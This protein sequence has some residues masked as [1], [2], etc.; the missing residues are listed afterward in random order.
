VPAATALA[1]VPADPPAGEG[2]AP[3]AT[4]AAEGLAQ[5]IRAV[6][7]A[8]GTTETGPAL[9]TGLRTAGMAALLRVRHWLA[10]APAVR[11]VP[12]LPPSRCYALNWKTWQRK[13]LAVLELLV[14][15]AYAPT[16]L[17][18]WLPPVLSC[19]VRCPCPA[20]G[21]FV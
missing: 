17:D 18:A 5:Q 14:A 12:P 19:L 7:K 8:A 4:A 21:R 3:F 10:S 2:V 20:R 16:D 9:P 11:L 1:Q 13:R 6:G 15:L